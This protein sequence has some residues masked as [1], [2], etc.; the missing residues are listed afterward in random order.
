MVS[1]RIT[2]CLHLSPPNS[3][4]RPEGISTWL[5]I[6]HGSS[7]G[8]Y[9]NSRFPLTMNTVASIPGIAKGSVKGMKGIAEG[10]SIPRRPQGPIS[11]QIDPASASPQILLLKA[12]TPPTTAITI[13]IIP[14]IPHMSRKLRDSN[15]PGSSIGGSIPGLSGTPKMSKG[16]NTRA[17]IPKNTPPIP[18]IIQ[19]MPAAVGFQV[20]SISILS[21]SAG[22]ATHHPQFAS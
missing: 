16:S 13:A 14:N 20:L 6:S 22:W 8:L 2:H 12:Y 1:P 11:V 5:F 9:L 19:S 18:P 17:I 21:K 15:N 10:M 4:S 7:F 3:C